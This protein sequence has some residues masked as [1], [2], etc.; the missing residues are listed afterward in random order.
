ME[1]LLIPD[2]D[3]QLYS[4]KKK[5]KGSCMEQITGERM[6]VE[7]EARFFCGNMFYAGTVCNLSS[8]DMH[9]DTESCLPSGTS[10]MTII[11]NGKDLLQVNT[12]V[13]RLTRT[14]GCYDGMDVEIL[15]PSKN[16]LD[17]VNSQIPAYMIFEIY[18]EHF[19][20]TNTH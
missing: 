4:K 7:I 14:N 5:N 8:E 11:R 2:K 3:E 18:K 9:I 17:Y 15:K 16:Y 6:P 19:Q 13:K 1:K 20:M 12:K 10:F